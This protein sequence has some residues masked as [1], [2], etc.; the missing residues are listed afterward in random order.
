MLPENIL[1]YFRSTPLGQEAEMYNTEINIGVDAIVTAAAHA[2]RMDAIA[3]GVR[4]AADI[5]DTYIDLND[6]GHFG[7][8]HNAENLYRDF[9]RS[10]SQRPHF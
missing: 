5:T 8:N 10:R 4:L 3:A 7:V 6:A 2:A 1:S 9:M